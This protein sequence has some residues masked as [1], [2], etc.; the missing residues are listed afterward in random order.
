[1]SHPRIHIF[2]MARGE[3][4]RLRPLTT[5]RSKPAT[6]FGNGHRLIDFALSNIQQLDASSVTV[7]GPSKQHCPILHSHVS[8]H[9]SKSH[10]QPMCETSGL[11]GNAESVRQALINA[12]IQ[13]TDIV[14]VFPSDQLLYI[15]LNETLRAHIHS[16][17]PA[18]LLS[19]WHPANMSKHLG[20][21]KQKHG[22]VVEYI[23]KPS[24][25][26]RNFVVD[27]HCLVNMGIYWFNAS[28]L[29]RT[30]NT[31]T[32]SLKQDFGHDI[33]PLL[34][35]QENLQCIELPKETP[36]KDLGTIE[37]YWQAHW[38]H[39]P[40]SS[41][42]WQINQTLNATIR[43]NNLYAHSPIPT[44][45]HTSKTIVHSNVSV[46]QHCSLNHVLLDDECF[47]EPYTELSI[48][49]EVI[50]HVYRTK[51]CLIIPARSRVFHS[52]DSNSLIVE[53]R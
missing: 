48:D 8:T 30:L 53:P 46:G 39:P 51:D 12:D 9:W 37:A 41:L 52:A 14:G 19:M 4:L 26:L 22:R 36:W 2:V 35:S 29:K 24:S 11:I 50:G 16:G 6:P 45:V 38:N 42:H 18:S 7:L 31:S 21:L 13:E 27:A 33:L 23:E 49:S 32:L 43:P 20:V 25:I 1:M 5:V 28:F 15:D 47:V 3:G 17:S 10:Y 44:S 40:N 34:V